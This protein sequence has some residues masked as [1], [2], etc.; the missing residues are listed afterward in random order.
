MKIETLPL[1]TRFIAKL[2]DYGS[3]LVKVHDPSIHKMQRCTEYKRLEIEYKVPVS[4]NIRFNP[5]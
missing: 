1:M 2:V 5:F 3:D 4:L